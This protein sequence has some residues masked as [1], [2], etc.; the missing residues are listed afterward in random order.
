MDCG[1]PGSS[2]Y[3]ISID[4]KYWNELPFPFPGDLPEPTSPELSAGFFTTEP[5]EKGA[6]IS[7]CFTLKSESSSSYLT[8]CRVSPPVFPGASR[9]IS[10]GR[11]ALKPPSSVFPA[12]VTLTSNFG[13]SHPFLSCYFPQT[14]VI[15]WTDLL[16]VWSI[17]DSYST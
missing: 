15:V 14:K 3:G 13:H 12:L 11:Y 10:L 5:P 8:G 17:E 6:Q 9:Q 16:K 7:P 4:K 2:V 1:P